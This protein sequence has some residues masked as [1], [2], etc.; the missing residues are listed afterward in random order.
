[1]GFFAPRL[2]S[3]SL[4][5]Y[6]WQLLLFKS[7]QQLPSITPNQCQTERKYKYKWDRHQ[8]GHQQGRLLQG[9]GDGWDFDSAVRP[10][11]DKLN[12]PENAVRIVKQTR[13]TQ[14]ANMVA[15]FFIGMG[16]FSSAIQFLVISHCV[17]FVCC[18]TQLGMI[19]EETD[20]ESQ[21]T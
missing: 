3:P 9:Q 8:L 11:L 15:R 19:R 12:D 17:M 10:F 16:D 18:Y 20:R 2:P 14:G 6:N 21:P 1:M 5:K 13:S 4:S 7:F